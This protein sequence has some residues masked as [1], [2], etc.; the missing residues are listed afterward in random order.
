MYI[1]L[2][3]EQIPGKNVVKARVQWP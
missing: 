3:E 2:S 1:N